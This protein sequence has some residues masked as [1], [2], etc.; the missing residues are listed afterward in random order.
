[1][2]G[3]SRAPSSAPRSRPSRT[4][5][6]SAPVTLTMRPGSSARRPS[7]AISAGSSVTAPSTAIATTTIAPMA[8]DR[9]TV[10]L[11]RN[12][13]AIE[14]R[15]V[16]PEKTTVAPEVRM[17]TS[18]AC[19][20]SLPAV[21]LLAV[22]REQE[23]RVVDGH[24]DAEHRRHVGHEDRHRRGQRQEVDGG[25]GDQHRG[26]AEADRQQRRQ[27][28]AEDHEQHDQDR[29]EARR[30]RL[31]E[32]LLL[33]LLHA[34]PQRRLAD[35]V[36][37]DAVDAP[38]RPAAPRAAPSR[39]RAPRRGRPRTPAARRAGSRSRV[40]SSGSATPSTAVDGLLDAVDRRCRIV[41][42]E[43][44]GERLRAARPRSG[45]SAPRPPPSRCPAPRSRRP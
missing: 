29:R 13:P 25:A 36:R 37:L 40:T 11:S 23:Q 2:A 24:A 28:R 32:V 6:A 7:R 35:H 14:I 41:A 38:R 20:R 15:T 30:L 12:S 5:R 19:A 27:H 22:A 45:R 43:H 4:R 8:S 33:E 17:A 26:D 1:M 10:E 18:S 31:G 16:T 44:D 21:D 42:L 3:A 39:R 9:M 34:R